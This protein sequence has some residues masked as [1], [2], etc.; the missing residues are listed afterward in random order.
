MYDDWLKPGR[1]RRMTYASLF[2]LAVLV[3]LA[4]FTG[5]IG[6]DDLAYSY[7][8]Q[9]VSEF[10]YEYNL[11]HFGPR[12]GVTI[13]VGVSYRLFGIGESVTVLVPLVTSAASVPLLVEI[14]RRLFTARAGLLAGIFL[15][16]FPIQVRYAT[17]LVPEPIMEFWVLV[18]VIMYFDSRANNRW[19]SPFLAG[20]TFGVAYLSKEVALFV[21]AAFVIDA[22]L[23]SQWRLALALTAGLAAVGASELIFYGAATGDPLYRAHVIAS[24]QA[25]YFSDSVAQL[26]SAWRLLK[27]YP[28][29][30]LVPN[31]NLG[32]HSLVALLIVGAG[33]RASPRHAVRTLILWAGLP[34]A[35]LNF[36][37]ASLSNYLPVAFAPRYIGIIYA[38]LF[39][40]AGAILDRWM[41]KAKSARFLCWTA[42]SVIVLSGLATSYAT[43]A[44]G[45]RTADVASLRAMQQTR[46]HTNEVIVAFEGPWAQ[47]WQFIARLL[48]GS[49]SYASTCSDSCLV[50]QPDALGLP[51]ATR[52]PT[53]KREIG[54]PLLVF[55]L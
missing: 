30:M 47:R 36:G 6:S 55:P 11:S 44:Q 53:E 3:R 54:T 29:E 8:A 17:V 46:H 34:M 13:P 24:S 45:Y 41:A 42:L 1:N 4:C 15:L 35:Y 40:L 9:L 5:L 52:L 48:G 10:R 43:R 37:S 27:A 7:F 22:L 19:M 12:V 49:R 50:V 20:V 18:A 14:G 23:S 25:A 38:P 21:G 31:F 32:L 26:K 51:H 2:S 39:L 16:T 28:Y 33:T